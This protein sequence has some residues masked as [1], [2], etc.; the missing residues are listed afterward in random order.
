MLSPLSKT[1]CLYSEVVVTRKWEKQERTQHGYKTVKGTSVVQTLKAGAVFG[2][3]DGSGVVF[4][5]ASKGGDF[6]NLTKHSEAGGVFMSDGYLKFGELRI[7]TPPSSI[8][9]YTLGFEA[10]E[11]IVP[12][13]GA[14]FALGKLEAGKIQKPGWRSMLFSSKGRAGLLASTAKKKK[15]AFV[16]GGLGALA[17]IPLMS[18]R[19]PPTVPRSSAAR[20]RGATGG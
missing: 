4:V 8:G 1:E 2:L 15:V 7:P 3:D 6:D 17:A 5:D 20:R 9:D 14:L 11:R 16:G 18:S 10:V 19:R 12:V 13:A